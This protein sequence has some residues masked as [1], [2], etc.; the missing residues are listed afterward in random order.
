MFWAEVSWLERWKGLDGFFKVLVIPL[1]IVQC[2]RS[3]KARQVFVG[4]LIACALLLIGSWV[5]AIW[6]QLPR[7]SYTPGVAVKS[8]I[9]QSAE[10]LLCTA[11]LIYLAIE[12]AR[13]YRWAQSLALLVLAIGFLTDIVFI[14]T[15]RTTLV[16]VPILTLVYAL[17]PF[18]WKR[19][20]AT[21]G[22]GLVLAIAAWSTSPYLRLR[23][24]SVFSQTNAFERQNAVNPSGERIVF[25][26]NSF[27]FIETAPII[28]HGTGSIAALFKAAARG[29][30]GVWAE[31]STNPHNQTFAVAIQLGLLGA[32]VLW[33]MWAAHFLVF[34]REGFAAWLGT[35]IVTLTVVGSLFNSFLFDFTEGWLYVIGVGVAAGTVLRQ[36]DAKAD[37]IKPA[38]AAKA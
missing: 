22:V 10:F 29:R 4:F 9:V 19:L 21:L 27:H 16:T 37:G 5:T 15:S 1:L 33:A 32:V 7:G 8:Y 17:R 18:N 28:G 26:T 38:A 30:T 2:R 23:V 11:T 25:W 12:R 20:F 6:P 36:S 35:T 31:A 3:D 24:T 13:D 34:S 14:A